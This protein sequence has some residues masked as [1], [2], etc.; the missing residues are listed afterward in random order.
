MTDFRKLINKIVE[1]YCA[2]Y[3]IKPTDLRFRI[4]NT[5][6]RKVVDGVHVSAMRMCLGHLF[7]TTFNLKLIQIAELVGYTDH[8]VLSGNRK[9]MRYYIDNQ[10]TFIMMYYLPLLKIAERYEDE[11]SLYRKCKPLHEYEQI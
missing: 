7:D 2:E 3:N 10:D 4:G 6:R 8:S 11:I 1:D 5:G 9:R